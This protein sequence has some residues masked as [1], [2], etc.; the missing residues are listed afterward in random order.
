M[1]FLF[2]FFQKNGTSPGNLTI[3]TGID[4]ILNLG[5]VVAW[6]DETELDIWRKGSAC[7]AIKGTDG[8]LFHPNILQNETLYLFNRDLCRSISLVYQKD[9]ASN[10]VPGYR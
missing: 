9:I 6:N 4:D 10:G 1:N 5:K 2:S 3:K 8:S 7:N